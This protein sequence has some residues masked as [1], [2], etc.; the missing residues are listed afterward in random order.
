MTGL[1]LI[2]NLIAIGLLIDRGIFF[3]DFVGQWQLCAY[4][5][6]GIDPYPLIGVETPA[7]AELGAI[8]SGWGT[9]PWGLLLGNFFYAGFLR[10]DAAE[11]LF[12]VLNLMWLLLTAFLFF[13]KSRELS[14]LIMFLCPASF[15][16]AMFT[17]NAG[18]IICAMLLTC[19]LI[20]EQLPIPAAVLLSLAMVKPQI[21]LAFCILFLFQRRFKLLMTAATIDLASWLIVSIVV[22]RSPVV[23]LQEFLQANVGGGA[24]FSGIFTLFIDSPNSAMLASMILGAAF[25]HALRSVDATCLAS[26]FWSYS[27]F[28]EFFVLTLPAM[29]CFRLKKKLLGIA[30]HVGIVFWTAVAFWHRRQL[31]LGL[32]ENDGVIAELFRLEDWLEVRTIFCLLFIAAGFFLHQSPPSP[33]SPSLSSKS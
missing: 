9:A 8:P 22:E 12:I 26:A 4:A 20:A 23:L 11:S 16:I 33:S 1:L 25:I 19:V 10:L 13:L 7:I 21:A 14:T 32:I 31:E 5:L 2:L 18:A 28:N 15:A 3:D 6:H 27:F 24:Q 30:L 17:G 29:S